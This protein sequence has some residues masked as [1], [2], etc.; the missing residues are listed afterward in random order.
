MICLWHS[1]RIPSILV[2]KERNCFLSNPEHDISHFC[3]KMVIQDC[4][5]MNL[6]LEEYS[7]LM[8][9]LNSFMTEVVT[10]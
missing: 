6:E 8:V 10:I 7:F 3:W 5:G 2:V 4:W 9:T 1:R